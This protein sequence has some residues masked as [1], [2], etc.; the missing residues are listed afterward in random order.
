MK[1]DPDRSVVQVLF[2]IATPIY[3][4]KQSLLEIA[5]SL[6]LLAMTGTDSGR[7]EGLN[8]EILERSSK[9]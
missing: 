5:S 6:R 1:Y 4:G 2:V 3:R 9:A 8:Y 7:P